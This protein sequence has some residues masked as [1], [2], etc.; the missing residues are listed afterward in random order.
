V[1]DFKYGLIAATFTPFKKNFELDTSKIG[2]LIEKLLRCGVE[3][4]FVAGTTG[5]GL[6]L[7]V[8]ER[9]KLLE[10]FVNNASGRVKVIVHVGA[11]SIE[12]ARKLAA[13]ANDI[14]AD[15][16]A[17]LL[18]FYYKKVGIEQYLE[19]LCEVAKSAENLPLYLY[20]IPS[21]TGTSVNLDRFLSQALNM[22]NNFAGVK[23]SSPNLMELMSLRESYRGLKFFFGVDEMMI[24]ALPLKVDGFIGS[25]YN[26]AS[27][28]YIQIIEAFRRKDFDQAVYLQSL[29]L[30][31]IQVLNSFGGLPAFKA[32]MKLIGLDIGPCRPPLG[33]FDDARLPDLKKS[34]RAIGVLDFLG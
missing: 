12:D 26:F 19:F 13:H 10:S 17:L 34:L 7:C 31:M 21:L 9:M 32:V 5:E 16:I 15:G 14:G 11:L 1:K 22:I 8:E 27:R 33:P 29:S 30:K 24:H 3:G 23:Y 4:F 28:L 6:S 25:T 20:Y 18:P 2:D